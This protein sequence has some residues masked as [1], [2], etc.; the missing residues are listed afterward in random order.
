MELPVVSAL[1]FDQI[2][3]SIKTFIK[4][5]SDFKD[6]DFEGSNMSMLVDI[7]TY[8]TL[9]TSYNVN[10]A[11]NELNLDTA[12]LRDNVVTIAKRLG[13][14]ANSYTSSRVNINV[15]VSNLALYDAVK[16]KRGAVLSASDSG[17]NFTFL[18]R[19]DLQLSVKGRNEISFTDV[20]LV[21]GREF[22]ITYVVDDT[23][24]HQRFFIPNN[25]IDS[26]SIRVSVISDPTNNRE[27]EYTRKNTI[28]EVSGADKV[29]FVEEVQDQKYEVVFGDD[30]IGRKVRDGEIIKIR[31]VITSGGLAN[32]ISTFNFLG[33]VVGINTSGETTLKSPYVTYEVISDFSDGGSEFETIKSIKYRAPRYYAAQER[34]VTLSDYE[35]LIQQIYSNADLVKVVGGE[36]LFPPKYGTVQISIKPIIGETVSSIEK[37]RIKRELSKFKVGSVEVDLLD[38]TNITIFAKPYVIFDE[39]KTKNKEYDLL[40]L[41]NQFVTNYLNSDEFKAF[42][43]KYSDLKVRC[44]IK[45]L[46]PAIED[47]NVPIYLQQ[48]VD[49]VPGV[50]TNYEVNFYTKLRDSSQNS[51]YYIISEPFCHE[52]ISSPVFLASPTNCTGDDTVKMY[53]VG[54]VFVKNVGKAEIDIG[55]ITFDLKACQDSPI[56]IT[57][58]PEVLDIDFGPDVVPELV[59]EPPVINDLIEELDDKIDLLDPDIPILPID[60]ILDEPDVDGDPFV[61]IDPTVIPP[62]TDGP[63]GGIPDVTDPTIPGTDDP[64]TTDD[65]PDPNDIDILDDYTPETNPYSCS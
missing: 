46:D 20:E 50:E 58:L 39:T 28:V 17:K 10:M 45:D 38:P 18:T 53:T 14:T 31:Y 55:K 32:N 23:N 41:I 49:L 8:N 61:T 24:E 19:D 21:E 6:Y 40:T 37:Q 15:T 27:E 16:I 65:L 48:S 5:K 44:G 3:S 43:G 54:G 12:V 30:V 26:D 35:S 62:I 52:G 57:V 64:G 7:L 60:T 11:S 63:G 25:F 47:V 9:Y 51:P 36:S 56:N 1:E 34:A 33:S 59:L 2:R 29:F 13:Y 4:T 22:A 42:G